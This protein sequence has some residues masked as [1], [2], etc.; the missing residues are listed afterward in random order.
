[1]RDQQ[2]HGVRR[3]WAD[4]PLHRGRGLAARHRQH[5]G[6]RARRSDRDGAGRRAGRRLRWPMSSCD[7]AAC[8][9]RRPCRRLPASRSARRRR[10][11][12]AIDVTLIANGVLVHPGAGSRRYARRGGISAACSTC[13]R[14]ARS[15]GRRSWRRAARAASSRSR[16]TRCTAGSAAPWR[17]WWCK[18]APVRCALLGVPGVFAPTGSPTFLF[19]HFGLT[20]VGIRRRRPRAAGI[21]SHAPTSAFSSGLTREPPTPRGRPG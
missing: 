19:E 5:D 14:S 8:R 4:A 3:A 13:P 18:N 6:D 11:A 1:M 20:A 2:R 15:T 7:S 17:K 9:C 16:S 12:T 21:E 10:C